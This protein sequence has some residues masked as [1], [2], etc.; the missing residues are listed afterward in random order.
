MARADASRALAMRW[1]ATLDER[2]FRPSLEQL[3]RVNGGDLVVGEARDRRM[4]LAA[5]RYAGLFADHVAQD[6]E[7]E[8]GPGAYALVWACARLAFIESFVPPAT[9]AAL[10]A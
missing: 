5:D 10:Q 4:R 6:V 8:A 3:A 2:P 9:S 1:V 7:V